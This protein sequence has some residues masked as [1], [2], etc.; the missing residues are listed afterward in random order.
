MDIGSLLFILNSINLGA[1]LDIENTITPAS[2]LS[3]EP[4][5]IVLWSFYYRY[6]R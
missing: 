6:R 2:D 4:A 3:Y 5:R 1:V